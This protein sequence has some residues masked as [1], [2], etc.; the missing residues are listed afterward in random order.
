MLKVIDINKSGR[1]PIMDKPPIERVKVI[2][3]HL[4]TVK[5]K[6]SHLFIYADSVRITPERLL[7]A[8]ID[9]KN[10]HKEDK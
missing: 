7:N 10:R 8:L 2:E 9:I 1:L 6:Q 4:S 3:Q 5:H